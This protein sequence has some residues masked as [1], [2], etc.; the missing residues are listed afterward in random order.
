MSARCSRSSSTRPTVRPLTRMLS[1]SSFCRS[2][3]AWRNVRYR[4][5]GRATNSAT[6]ISA[7]TFSERSRRP[8]RAALS[9]MAPAVTETGIGFDGVEIRIEIA[10]FL[11]DALHHR[12]HVGA[13]A[14]GPLPRLEADAA[15]GVVDLAV[16]DIAADAL[17][18]QLHHLEFA[19]GQFDLLA[20]PGGPR[21]GDRSEEHTSALQSRE[22]LVC[23]PPL[24][25]NNYATH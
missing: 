2:R 25:K 16:A 5:G 11:P 1:S 4:I 7:R 19:M 17:R 10:E 6:T 23:R 13:I 24:G 15:D 14:I 21:R 8:K 9:A 12:A 3:S 20:V 18:Q 22:T